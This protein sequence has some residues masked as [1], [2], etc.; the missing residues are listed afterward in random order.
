MQ[1]WRG[2]EESREGGA[3]RGEKAAV[4]PDGVIRCAPTPASA[5]RTCCWRS[6]ASSRCAPGTRR[7]GAA[8]GGS[9]AGEVGSWRRTAGGVDPAALATEA[10]RSPSAL[11]AEAPCM[12]AAAMTRSPF[13]ALG[14]SWRTPYWRPPPPRYCTASPVLLSELFLRCDR[15]F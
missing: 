13:M 1:K 6:G 2:R 14:P 12:L 3:D 11:A 7:P 5:S 15:Y 10:P 4:V 8:P 9:A